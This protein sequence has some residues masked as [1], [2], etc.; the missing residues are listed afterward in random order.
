MKKG[1]TRVYFVKARLTEEEYERFLGKVKESY[2]PKNQSDYIR[3][4]IFS[5]ELQ[6][7]AAVARELKN[8]N[9]QIRKIGV[10]INQIAAGVN[11][12]IVYRG[13]AKLVVSKLG[14]VERLLE[15]FPERLGIHPLSDAEKNE[16]EVE[17]GAD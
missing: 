15:G 12:G 9:Y 1:N 17:N 11:S 16:T 5:D 4:C 7:S 10:L 6:H 2:N 13:D 8:L 3:N 14:E